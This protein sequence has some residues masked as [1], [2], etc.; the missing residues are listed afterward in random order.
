MN[1]VEIDQAVSELFHQP[2]DAAEFPFQ[3]LAAFE[4]ELIV[5]RTGAGRVRAKARGV[6]MGRPPMLTM[7]QRKEALDELAA[8][9]MPTVTPILRWY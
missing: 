4:R 9:T 8:H 2:F 3:F 5:T 7:Q 1:A 6:H